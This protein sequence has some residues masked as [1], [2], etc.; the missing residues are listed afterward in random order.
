ML[1][2]DHPSYHNLLNKCRLLMVETQAT[3]LKI[4]REANAVTDVLVKE[5]T[6]C[7]RIRSP[8][9]FWHMPHFVTNLMLFDNE[10]PPL[11]S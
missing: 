2:N 4:F 5:G 11:K 9:L 1:K 7:T 6:K 8:M 3:P 10:G